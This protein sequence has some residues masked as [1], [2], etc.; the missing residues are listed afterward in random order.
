ML[1]GWVETNPSNICK[2]LYL[3]SSKAISTVPWGKVKTD[4][5]TENTDVRWVGL[6][7]LM[8]F[9]FIN[10]TNYLIEEV[11]CT[12]PSLHLV[13]HGASKKHSSL[14]IKDVNHREKRFYNLWFRFFHTFSRKKDSP[15]GFQIENDFRR[16]RSQIREVNSPAEFYRSS[17]FFVFILCFLCIINAQPNPSVCLVFAY[18]CRQSVCSLSLYLFICPPVHKS[19]FLMFIFSFCLSVNLCV[20]LVVFSICLSILFSLSVC[21]L[22]CLYGRLFC[23]SICLVLFACLCVRLSILHFGFLL[24][25]LSLLFVC[26]TIWLPAKICLS[27]INMNLPVNRH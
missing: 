24:A 3:T 14:F 8:L 18:I 22:V 26:W 7:P 12:E 11:D 1:F 21:Q 23:L 2:H 13:F 17:C 20:C 6:H 25:S 4:V 10:K 16:R 5:R 27:K 19:V 15:N 9:T